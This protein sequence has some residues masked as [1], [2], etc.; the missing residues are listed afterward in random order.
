[1]DRGTGD[2]GVSEAVGF[3]LVFGMLVI[4]FTVYQGI[5]V[6]D[7]NRQVEFQ[8]NQE[9]QG[10]L[11]DLRNAIVT[12]AATGSGQAVSVTLGASYPR[13]ALA[14]N[15]GVSGGAI[16]TADASGAGIRITNARA[17][18]GEAADYLDGTQLS[19]ETASIRYTPVYTF[20]SNAPETVY[21]NTLLYNQFDGANVTL[22]GQVLV[23]GRRITL[24]AVN[25]SL[26]AA[27]RDTVSVGTEAISASSNRVAVRNTSDEQV[28]VTIPTRMSATRWEEVLAGE[29]GTDGYVVGVSA[30]PGEDAVNVT[31]EQ[32][33][34]YELRMAKVGV[35]DSTREEPAEYVIDV[36]GNG[37]S[38][39]EGGKQRLIVEVRDRFNNP[40][41]NVTVEAEI[42]Q[43]A[44]PLDDLSPAEA[45]TDANGRASFTY[46]AHQQVHDTEEAIVEV[47][48]DGWGDEAR[49]ASFHVSVLN[50]DGSGGGPPGGGGGRP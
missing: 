15:L 41:S 10:Q 1:M 19:F 29:M 21:E 25:G 26:S 4:A 46:T 50:S 34:T 39:P 16:Q 28:N 38:I 47:S 44:G 23:D 40:T 36:D 45:T 24:I 5:V 42:D 14:Q 11:Q 8:H 6:P 43:E 2:R 17:V 30:V 37:S 20:Y 18:D 48:F 9:V 13:R 7:Q 3:I 22:T 27:E 35:G 32:G 49:I 33:V 12:T 31:M